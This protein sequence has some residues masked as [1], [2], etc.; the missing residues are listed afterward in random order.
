METIYNRKIPGAFTMNS[1]DVNFLVGLPYEKGSF[2]PESF[3]CWG[4]LYFVQLNYFKVQIPFAPLEDSEGCRKLFDDQLG[5]GSWARLER[6]EHGCGALM[7]GGETPHVGIYLD[8]DGGGILHA[9]EG[10]GVIW[11][12]FYKLRSLSFGRTQYYRLN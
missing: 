9:M 2:G 8:I 10:V 6:P 1:H 4:L 7:R 3:N 5:Q 12:P 11:T